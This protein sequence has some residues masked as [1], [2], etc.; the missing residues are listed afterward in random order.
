MNDP[1]LTSPLL[2]TVDQILGQFLTGRDPGFFFW[3]SV[4]YTGVIVLWMF[5]QKL[6]AIMGRG[7]SQMIYRLSKRTL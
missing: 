5:R 1:L 7:F 3:F 2:K 4:L 6:T